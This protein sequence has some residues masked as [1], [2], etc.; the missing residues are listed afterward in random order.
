MEDFDDSPE[1]KDRCAKRGPGLDLQPPERR[2]TDATFPRSV[3]VASWNGMLKTIGAKPRPIGHS[4][5]FHSSSTV[6]KP[7]PGGRGCTPS[8]SIRPGLTPGG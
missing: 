3:P 8:C 1:Q 4:C 5:T 2:R 6:R 7:I